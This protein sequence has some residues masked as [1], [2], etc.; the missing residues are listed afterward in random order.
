MLLFE[1]ILENF[2]NNLEIMNHLIWVFTHIA[3][4]S[5]NIKNI[6]LSS[7]IFKLITNI[8]KE[9]TIK[10]DILKIV[11]WFMASLAKE[12]KAGTILQ[13]KK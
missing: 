6:I 4:D 12:K 10:Q 11:C 9:N 8:L 5:T 7:P 3:H 1:K 2:K 13:V